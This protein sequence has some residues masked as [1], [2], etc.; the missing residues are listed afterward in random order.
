MRWVY[1]AR[2][3]WQPVREEDCDALDE[4]WRARCAPSRGGRVRRVRLSGGLVAEATRAPRPRGDAD[5]AD[6]DDRPGGRR[7]GWMM[8]LKDHESKQ[9]CLLRRGWRANL[10]PTVASA[11][12]A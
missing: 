3:L 2:G 7:L 11:W 6:D 4:F 10:P 8:T 5:G 9:A 12:T 1:R